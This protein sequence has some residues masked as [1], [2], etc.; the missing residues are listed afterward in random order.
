MDA[1]K[2]DLSFKHLGD[3]GASEIASFV[4][5]STK[6]KHLNL[7]KF[8]YDYKMSESN[9]LGKNAAIDLANAFSMSKSLETVE[10]CKYESLD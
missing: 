6:L 3:I 2:I 10:L 4:A 7:S 1:T 8:A 9:S 5:V